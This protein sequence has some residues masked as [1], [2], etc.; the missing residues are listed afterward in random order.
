MS[1]LRQV[2]FF[3]SK[4]NTQLNEFGFIDIP[5]YPF[6]M[7]LILELAIDPAPSFVQDA[8]EFSVKGD[9]SES[10][11]ERCNVLEIMVKSVAPDVSNCVV[12]LH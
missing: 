8:W 5:K 12:L 10:L 9:Y 2:S 11:A 7:R 1:R 4:C 3:V 6:I